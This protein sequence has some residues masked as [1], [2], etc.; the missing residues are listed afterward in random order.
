MDT[1]GMMQ[2]DSRSLN[3]GPLQRPVMGSPQYVMGNAYSAAPMTT[4]AAP[5][6]DPQPAFGYGN[7]APSSPAVAPSFKQQ[8]SDRPTPRVMPSAP[9][10]DRGLAYP[11]DCSTHEQSRS[12]SLKSEPISAVKSRNNSITTP[13]TVKA[14]V[15]VK[16]PN[17]ATFSTDIDILM[18]AIQAKKEQDDHA[19]TER[20]PSPQS[21]NEMSQQDGK[22]GQKRYRCDFDDCGYSAD[23]K[24]HLDIHWRTHTGEKPYICKY[25]GCNSK[26]TQHGNLKTHENRHTGHKPYPCPECG[27]KFA[28]RGN[29]RAHLHTH[30]QTKPFCCILDNCYKRF[31]QRGNLKQHQ[32]KFHEST[33]KKLAAKF[34][35]MENP[36]NLSKA[37][38]ELWQY[39]AD[40]YKNSNKGIKGRGKNRNVGPVARISPV[41]PNSGISPQYPV[42]QHHHAQMP[43]PTHHHGLSHPAAYSMSRG[44]PG[45]NIMVG[46]DGL[47]AHRDAH[48]YEMYDDTDSINGSGTAS[49]MSG[50]MYDEDH[51]RPDLG[52]NDRMY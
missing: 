52:F 12:P 24:T 32:N 17:E 13:K 7:Y 36:E 39:F 22:Q 8:F 16:S 9:E 47:P 43:P 6:Y 40:L 14:N 31:T 21:D 3:S 15:S 29:V 38:Q 37:D 35:T 4:M 27:K 34:A 18:K 5:S 1:S 42:Q 26:F 50:T 11:R 20:T 10:L 41:I 25:P 23:Q 51:G 48:G 45:L 49:T 46:P 44:A 33:V 28:Q 2:Y 19:R 30:S